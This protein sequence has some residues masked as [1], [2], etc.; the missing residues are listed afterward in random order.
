MFI[1][2]SRS[3]FLSVI[4]VWDVSEIILSGHGL[5][6]P[7]L[8]RPLLSC[9][10]PFSYFSRFYFTV[11]LLSL[12]L[13]HLVS[14]SLLL[15][16]PSLWRHCPVDITNRPPGSRV[17]I[18][19]IKIVRL[20]EI[21]SL[22]QKK[23]LVTSLIRTPS[24]RNDRSLSHSGEL[25]NL[26]ASSL[27]YD[28]CCFDRLG[29]VFVLMDLW[30]NGRF[31]KREGK[32][33][34]SEAIEITIPFWCHLSKETSSPHLLFFLEW[35][36]RRFSKSSF[37]CNMIR[38]PK[39]IRTLGSFLYVAMSKTN[40]GRK[41]TNGLMQ[42]IYISFLRLFTDLTTAWRPIQH[43]KGALETSISLALQKLLTS[44]R[45]HDIQL[46][47]AAKDGNRGFKMYSFGVSCNWW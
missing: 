9:R 29:A 24:E 45:T 2:K 28:S 18:T 6:S 43:R 25:S 33:Y 44:V 36:M 17:W 42:Y 4:T 41:E 31:A 19:S 3:L 37:Y 16:V 15:Q 10:N 39:V 47:W 23:K 34:S 12:S 22:N 1:N 26:S 40:D 7:F 13:S 30:S 46:I 21:D 20:K 35:E 14:R 27:F 38:G 11:L 8:L 5:L 32:A